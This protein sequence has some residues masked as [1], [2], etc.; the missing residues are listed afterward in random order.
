MLWPGMLMAQP[1]LGPAVA[2][3]LPPPAASVGPML[4]S[5]PMARTPPP[6][7]RTLPP[8][9]RT[10]PARATI[11]SLHALRSIRHV[12]CVRCATSV[13]AGARQRVLRSIRCFTHGRPAGVIP[14][15]IAGAI[16][17][18]LAGAIAVAPR[19][20]GRRGRRCWRRPCSRTRSC[21]A[22]RP[23]SQR[24]LRG[25]AWCGRSRAAA[26]NRT[27]PHRTALNR[28]EPK[29]L[30]RRVHGAAHGALRMPAVCECTALPR[31]WGRGA[32]LPGARHTNLCGGRVCNVLGG[33][34][35]ASIR[36]PYEDPHQ[37]EDPPP[38]R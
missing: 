6:A 28:S 9:S 18:V 21:S 35:R 5:L 12:R 10:L 17:G 7:S 16:A 4:G 27:E 1:Q 11:D 19:W 2:G 20:R 29:R 8:S 25:A 30:G 26:P 13:M 37:Y 32:E 22:P 31:C 3:G 24:A 36:L 38:V 23:R 14:G 33:P 34:L 15:A